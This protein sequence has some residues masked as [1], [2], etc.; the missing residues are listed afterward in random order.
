MRGKKPNRPLPRAAKPKPKEEALM[1]RTVTT[2]PATEPTTLLASLPVITV[3]NYAA[4]S[5]ELERLYEKA[6][7]LQWNG[8]EQL[9]W[10]TNVDPEREIIPSAGDSIVNSPH[11]ARMSSGDKRRYTH[12]RLAW[13]LSQFLHGEQGALYAAAQLAC[14]V[15]SIEATLYA[16]T[17]VMDEARHVEV[18][19]RYLFDKVELQLPVNPELQRLLNA[20]LADSRWDM[21][22]LGMQIM[23]EGLALAAFKSMRMILEQT[24]AEPLLYQLIGYVLR[25]EARHT[26]FG[27][28]NLPAYLAELTEVELQERREFVYEATV[29]MGC[30]LNG[31]EVLELAGLS[32]AEAAQLVNQSES[33]RRFRKQ[34][35]LIIVSLIDRLRLFNP[36]LEKRFSE[37]DILQFRGLEIDLDTALP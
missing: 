36:W 15:P 34:L 31:G 27:V 13:Q 4:V 3:T 14:A 28:E 11:W 12:L 30:R 20:I 10:T 8:T 35:F 5:S 16:A 25:D 18:F 1:D 19:R 7:R 17:Q 23:V 26:A 21:K 9:P 33:L 29:L 2:T 37:L 6:K 32:K 22:T 24:G